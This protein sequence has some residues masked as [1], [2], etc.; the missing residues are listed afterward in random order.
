MKLIKNLGVELKGKW[1]INYAIYECPFC[2]KE[3]KANVDDIK[4][5]RK[6][7]CGCT[8]I[9]PE[10][11]PVING[12]T[13]LEDL[14][15]I[16][17]RRM[18]IFKCPL[19]DDGKFKAIVSDIRSS[20]DNR[21]RKHCGCYVKPKKEKIIKEKPIII[22][23]ERQP[24][25]TDHPLYSTWMGMRKR[26]YNPKHDSYKNYGGRGIVLCDRWF[27]SFIDFANDMGPKPDKS[28]TIDRINNDGMYE[29]GNCKWSSPAE[30]A[31]NK[32]PK[33]LKING[34]S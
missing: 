25:I 18:A 8:H 9:L 4:R 26:C 2:L 15:T 13:V 19:C 16:N 7:H 32:R 22:P 17:A 33:L 21:K 31:L 34:S 3:F 5:G 11:E 10:L 23:K 29:P 20:K 27:K 6:K 30:Q 14:R 24:K 1:L 28:Y 12:F